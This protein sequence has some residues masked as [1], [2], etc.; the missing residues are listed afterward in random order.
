LS[1]KTKGNKNKIVQLKNFIIGI[2]K[3]YLEPNKIFTK[4]SIKIFRKII[5]SR[6]IKIV[7]KNIFL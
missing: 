6:L 4:G 7:P 3:R 5:K 1:N 2:D